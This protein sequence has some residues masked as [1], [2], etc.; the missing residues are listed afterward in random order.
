MRQLMPHVR[1]QVPFLGPESQLKSGF[2]CAGLLCSES[3][4]LVA[5]NAVVIFSLL[6]GSAFAAILRSYFGT[7]QTAQNGTVKVIFFC[8]FT[9]LCMRS[10]RW[11]RQASPSFWDRVQGSFLKFFAVMVAEAQSFGFNETLLLVA[12]GRLPW[13]SIDSYQSFQPRK[14]MNHN[15]FSQSRDN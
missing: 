15:L 3:M 6:Q 12:T 4:L 11:D 5:Y 10:Q 1:F 8:S 13:P 7:A 14:N 9:K 2:E